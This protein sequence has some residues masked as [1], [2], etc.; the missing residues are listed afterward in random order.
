MCL[1]TWFGATKVLPTLYRWK[2]KM[3][4][5]LPLLFLQLLWKP[6]WCGGQWCAP[7]ESGVAN[8]PR[9]HQY[10]RTSEISDTR[11]LRCLILHTACPNYRSKTVLSPHSCDIYHL[12]VGTSVF[13]SRHICDCSSA[14]RECDGVKRCENVTG[15]LPIRRWLYLY[16]IKQVFENFE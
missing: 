1:C 7:W 3:L 4:F 11:N 6:N 13:L 14:I 2:A 16:F 5:P 15:L 9:R 10:I 8:L 12:H